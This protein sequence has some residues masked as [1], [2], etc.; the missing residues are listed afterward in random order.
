MY[1]DA[2]SEI[3]KEF[4]QAFND[5]FG[6]V[7]SFNENEIALQVRDDRKA[8]SIWAALWMA[9]RMALSLEPSRIADDIRQMAKDLVK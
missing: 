8:G 3:K 2:M 7:D 4:E 9:E 1:G 5:R 6:A